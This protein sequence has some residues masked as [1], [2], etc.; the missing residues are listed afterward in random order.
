MFDVRPYSNEEFEKK[1]LGKPKNIDYAFRYLNAMNGKTHEVVTGITMRKN[2][3][4]I[5]FSETTK[6]H[7]K[8]LD[9]A[10]IHQYIKK[11]NP[12][13]KAGAYNIQEYNGVE[14]IEGEFQNVMGLPIKRIIAEIKK[15]K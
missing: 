8:M 12:L 15:W 5:S 1:I 11:Y 4:Q 13:D 10:Q 14:K 7:F 2:K 9:E 6:V 3:K